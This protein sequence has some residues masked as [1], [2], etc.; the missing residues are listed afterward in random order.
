MIGASFDDADALNRSRKLV[1]CGVEV[2]D[3]APDVIVRRI[4]GAIRRGER[5]RVINANAHLITTAQRQP[6]LQELFR[7]AEVGFVD[8]A[9]PQ[10]ALWLRTGVKPARTTP[11]EWAD[12]VG[13]LAGTHGGSVFWLGGDAETVTRA[14]E[15]FSLQ[16]RVR[17]AGTHHGFFPLRGPE[18]EQV[19]A[20][21]N[22]AS[23][24]VLFLT[25]GMP[26]QE[27]WLHENWQ[28]ISAR[29]V[30]T[31]GALVDHAAG[32]VRRPPR[33]VADAGLEWAVRLIVEPRRLWK[34]YL[35]GLPLFAYH[36]ARNWRASGRRDV[37]S[38]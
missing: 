33:W 22:A 34:R 10:F 14:A 23:P 5:L 26:R 12:T 8:G 20:A 27:Q 19:V 29:I 28:R 13:R 7:E 1:L 4:E 37:A 11:P 38:P 21:I 16:N 35:L 36:V 17:T 18:N 32:K 25:M 15:A 3:L 30:I 31:A 6:W 9:G 2:R 24:D